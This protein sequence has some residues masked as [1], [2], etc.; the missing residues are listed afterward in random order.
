MNRFKNIDR[1]SVWLFL[2][3]LTACSFPWNQRINSVGIVFL[4]M[5]WLF[6]KQLVQKIKTIKFDAVLISFVTFFLYHLVALSWSDFKQDAS[7]SIEVKMSFLILPFL[8][9]TENYLNPKSKKQLLIAFCISCLLSFIYCLFYSVYHF[10]SFGISGIL[11]R[12]NISQ[13]IMHPGYYSN[14]FVLG[15]VFSAFE[16]IQNKNNPLKWFY[17]FIITIFSII[18]ALLVSKTALI[19]IFIFVI[20]VLWKLSDFIKNNILRLTSFIGLCLIFGF[21]F[22]FAPPIKS[23][24]IETLRESKVE[25]ANP[26]FSN[27]TIARRAAWNL[28]WQ[29]IKSNPIIGYGT[30][31]SNP[32][33]INKFKEKRYADLIKYNM[34]THNQF[35]HTWI[36]LGLI[37]II[38]LGCIL[39]FSFIQFF[40][41]KETI[42]MWFTVLVLINILTDDMLEIQAGTVFFVFFLLILIYQ[43][44]KKYTPTYY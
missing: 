24:I 2:V 31:A 21:I 7:H 37:G 30:G 20:F 41:H 18:L 12:M 6:D 22:S 23:R 27:S 10:H 40:K 5:H 29:L 38:L 19:F 11:N 3:I 14:Y 33:L 28:E 32:L 36:D 13:G 39:V 44:K 16:L 34:H 15:I 1:S 35:F 26:N 17:V 9:S 8:F 4:A 43:N 25:I 42:G